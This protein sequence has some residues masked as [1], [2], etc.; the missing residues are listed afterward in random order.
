MRTSV[1]SGLAFL[2]LISVVAATPVLAADAGCKV[3]MFE[4]DNY[5]GKKKCFSKNVSDL[6]G[7]GIGDEIS[8]IKIINGQCP[9]LKVEVYKDKDFQGDHRT[10]SKNESDFGDK[11]N[12]EI[13]SLQFFPQGKGI[14]ADA[15][16]CGVCLFEH[17]NYEG[18]SVCFSRT[19]DNFKD[20]KI[21]FNDK[22]SS[23]RLFTK[24][25][26]NLVVTAYEDS[27]F[28]GD[29]NLFDGDVKSLG[30]KLNDKI[31]SMQL[32]KGGKGKPGIDEDSE[33]QAILYDHVG[34]HGQYTTVKANRN[35]L[36]ELNGRVSSIKLF[37][38]ECKNL[39]LMLYSDKE[40][41]GEQ[42]EVSG[43]MSD[44][45]KFND[46]ARSL[47]FV[48]GGI[49]DPKQ[50]GICLYENWNYKGKE[51]CLN[52]S[53]ADLT[54]LDFND[55][56]SSLKVHTKA[57]PELSVMLF[58]MNHYLSPDMNIDEKNEKWWNY[59]NL[60]TLG[61]VD[62]EA[63]SDKIK[64]AQDDGA[65]VVYQ[66]V[67]KLDVLND[68]I[69][70]VFIDPG[71]N[72]GVDPRNLLDG[73][74]ACFYKERNFVGKYRCLTRKNNK[75]KGQNCEESEYDC[76]DLCLSNG[77]GS[78]LVIKDQC[79]NAK[80]G[81]YAEFDFKGRE[82]VIDETVADLAE[83]D[84][85]DN[86]KSAAINI[87]GKKLEVNAWENCGVCLHE[88]KDYKGDKVC[89]DKSVADLKEYHFDD[90]A[91]SVGVLTS[92]CPGMLV[93]LFEDKDF[94]GDKHRLIRGSLASVG[95]PLDGEISSV[96]LYRDGGDG[97][98]SHTK[99]CGFCLF[100][101]EA[102]TG[103]WVCFN[104]PVDTNLGGKIAG[105]ASSVWIDNAQCPKAKL[106]LY[107]KGGR[108]GDWL[109]L[110]QNI[111]DL[112]KMGFNDKARSVEFQ[113]E[114]LHGTHGDA[115]SGPS[116]DQTDG[117]DK[118]GPSKDQTGGGDTSGPS[119]DQTGGGDTSGPSHDQ[120]GGGDKASPGQEG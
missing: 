113:P 88:D 87:K 42:F 111:G 101:H 23:L 51:L 15:P 80:I 82:L 72:L 45:G 35:D 50:C 85:A 17:F 29:S 116:H 8:S 53:V 31:S 41:E 78:V 115:G 117:D 25:C 43:D 55:K 114:A 106:T 11:F 54:D 69:T 86:V 71:G 84:M 12:D 26:P 34:F 19:Q 14:P 3:C 22:A 37:T 2:L 49:R 74:G 118:S 10:I 81:L 105:E 16:D 64:K 58:D 76:G 60:L 92:E 4:H 13:S 108:N 65:R 24:G 66:D 112:G 90:K 44:L 99:G 32:W 103:E 110:R 38:E 6:H 52:L 40:G 94:Q 107:S 47:L 75:H 77:V 100:K 21:K 28:Q 20:S 98:W 89:F 61:Q 7:Q 48:K 96:R 30:G 83:V 5:G 73:C 1:V 63:V 119:H 120:T 36:K 39:G 56:A 93:E 104:G 95:Q 91:S 59:V 102:Y 62:W 79:P 46:K 70:S 97:P 109:S 9:D 67:P 57:C 68:Q 18:A 33:C 27:D